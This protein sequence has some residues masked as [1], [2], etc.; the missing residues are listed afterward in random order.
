M[1][2]VPNITALLILNSQNDLTAIR[3]ILHLHELLL[4][5]FLRERLFSQ[6]RV[7]FC[8]PKENILSQDCRSSTRSVHCGEFHHPSIC[9]NNL[10]AN[11]GEG[12]KQ[13]SD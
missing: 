13:C 8:G 3:D 9:K 7:M 1:P 6:D 5:I 11:K 4:G 12:N 10:G 2:R